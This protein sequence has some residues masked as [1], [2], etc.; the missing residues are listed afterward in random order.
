MDSIQ[1]QLM[2]GAGAGRRTTYSEPTITFGRDAQ[3]TVVIEDEF[4]SRQHGQICF[5]QDQWVLKNL[6]ANGTRLN[7]KQVKDKPIAIK[8]G[9]TVSIGKTKVFNIT[10]LADAAPLE[11]TGEAGELAQIETDAE[12]K[13]IAARR[14]KLWIGIGVYAAAMLGLFVFLKFNSM[15]TGP[16]V[17]Q[18]PP[19]LSAEQI[20]ADIRTELVRVESTS[21][22]QQSRGAA[23]MLFPHRN[24]GLKMLFQIHEYYREALA[25]SKK[26][27]FDNPTT[28][29]NFRTVRRALIKAVIKKYDH[30]YNKLGQND[31]RN[32]AIEFAEIIEF[33]RDDES[34]L[35]K[36]VERL[37]YYTTT[38]RKK[39]GR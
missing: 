38:E 39:R 15:G 3:C 23:E 21:K 29:I 20:A 16:A 12:E 22:A 33:Y 37:M 4:A 35:R 17:V 26:S 8:S 32:A 10:L 9:D 28:D 6:S 13:R 27:Q 11:E 1:I 24:E 30:A 18:M 14:M 7:R 5:E 2:S 34:R 36:N 31:Y 19:Q 25:Y